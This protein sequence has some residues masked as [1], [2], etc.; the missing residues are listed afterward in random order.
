[1]KDWRI[2]NHDW[3]MTAVI[4]LLTFIGLVVIYSAT[5]SAE[6]EIEGVGT[7]SRQLVFMILG[8]IIYFAV[9][10]IDPAFYRYFPV[11]VVIFVI[12]AGLLLFVWLF[13]DPVRNTNRWI[14]WGFVRI[15]P[16]EYSKITLILIN[17]SIL[18]DV[19][20]L[21]VRDGVDWGTLKK[22]FQFRENIKKTIR[23]ILAYNP[24]LFRYALGIVLSAIV[25]G[26]VLVE[27]ALGN[28]SIIA[29]IC[30]AL[31]IFA[32]PNQKYVIGL[33]IVFLL[34]INT[35]IGF[36][37]FAFLYDQLGI[38][39][40]VGNVDIMVL[41]LS[42]IAIVVLI[43]SFRLQILPIL[44]VIG[45][46]VVFFVSVGF[47]WNSDIIHP[48][49]KQRIETFLNPDEDTRGAAWQLRQ[50]KI[51]IGSG[52]IFGKGFLQGSQSK[53]RFL[54]EAYTDFIFAAYSEEFGLVGAGVLFSLYALLLYRIIKAAKNANDYYKSL[55]C[56]GVVVMITVHVFINT[57]MNMGILPVTGIPLPL[58]SYGGS[59]V[60]VTMIA[61]G[62]V[63][64]VNT[65]KD[66]VDMQQDMM[67]T[68][69]SVWRN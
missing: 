21:R 64:A 67:L 52:R 53:L 8:F 18:A 33:C 12:T 59:S 45:A 7:A 63:Q 58:I 20:Y 32:F 40:I 43:Y 41:V 46:V 19:L 26:L 55:L 29:L 69:K 22:K 57:G 16:S 65:H 47:I 62:L 36:I 66:I 17:A 24:I 48:Y 44:L 31:F 51:A 61:L 15:Q 4:F 10:R 60:M 42:V 35:L 5:F 39:L 6:T 38:N 13:G 56:I 25:V 2:K 23:S 14:E 34:T 54:P 1:M 37:N 9:S 30:I 3:I 49:Q 27:P 28:A 68:S 50:S 11:Q